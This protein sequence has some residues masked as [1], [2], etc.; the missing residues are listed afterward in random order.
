MNILSASYVLFI[1]V[2]VISYWLV[3]RS[4]RTG[5]LAAASLAFVAFGGLWAVALLVI[6]VSGAWWAGMATHRGLPRA[7]LVGAL[8]VVLSLI[9]FFAGKELATLTVDLN[10]LEGTVLPTGF[11]FYT[12][13][14]IA[15]VVDVGRGN[16]APEPSIVRLTAY[17]AF[18]PHLTVG[19]VM[20]PRR[21][22]PQ[23]GERLAAVDR[24]RLA[25]AF[26]LVLLGLFKKVCLGDYAIQL[27]FVADLTNPVQHVGYYLL[28]TLASFFSIAGA[29]D[30]ARGTGLLFG[31]NLPRS[32]AQ[33][34]TRARNLGDYWRRWQI[35]LMSWFREYVFRPVSE[36]VGGS[37]GLP[38]GILA[39]FLAASVWHAVSLE[40]LAWGLMTAA[41][42]LADR[43]IQV[44]NSRRTLS[45]PVR[46]FWRVT[47]RLGVYVYLLATTWAIAQLVGLEG[48][49]ASPAVRMATPT[50]EIVGMLGVMV[51]GLLA[52]DAYEHRL[53]LRE[54]EVRPTVARGLAWGIGLVAIIVFWDAAGYVPF[55]YEGF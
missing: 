3:P 12:F 15:Y 20:A 33:P 45:V 28:L 48:F 7:R 51:V 6:S 49:G 8:S 55:V 42:V 47:R 11:A 29:L 14:T 2:A 31:V 16:I 41:F 30:I 38:A 54:M 21:V 34:L 24:P 40:W 18:F 36:R 1:L 10:F 4:W 22:L 27:A 5:F 43:L 19:P 32:F 44:A 53:M 52:L 46:V 26:E 25:E 39:T 35:P 9:V 37:W 13:Q 23:F 17:V 50:S